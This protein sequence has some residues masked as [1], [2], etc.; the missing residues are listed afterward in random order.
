MRQGEKARILAPGDETCFT[1]LASASGVDE[2]GDQY[3]VRIVEV[4]LGSLAEFRVESGE[5]TDYICAAYDRIVTV[6]DPSEFVLR[7]TGCSFRFVGILQGGFKE[8]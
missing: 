7:A 6:N 8:I 5:H 1:T 2:R 3:E 4:P